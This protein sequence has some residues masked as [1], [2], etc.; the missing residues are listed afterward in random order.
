M[1][2]RPPAAGGRLDHHSPADTDREWLHVAGGHA[3]GAID[4]DGLRG[5]GG[6]TERSEGGG[7]QGAH[8]KACDHAG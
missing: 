6:C 7:Q 1:P 4:R 3:V 2:E 5:H 8:E